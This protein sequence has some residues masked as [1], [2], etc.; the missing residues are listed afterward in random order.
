M[1]INS[2]LD[3]GAWLKEDTKVSVPGFAIYSALPDY[4]MCITARARN[5]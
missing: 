1:I 2:I 4:D 5:P 3:A